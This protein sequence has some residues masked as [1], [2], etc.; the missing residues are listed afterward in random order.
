M[1]EKPSLENSK[2]LERW[3]LL[4]AQVL[5]VSWLNAVSW[6]KG[7]LAG[8]GWEVLGKLLV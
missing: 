4:L 7:I 6:V 5:G 3:L 2:V 1:L 8:M